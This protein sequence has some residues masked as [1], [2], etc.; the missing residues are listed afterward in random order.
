MGLFSKIF[1]DEKTEKAA[2]D[3]LKGILKSAV[4]D[5]ASEKAPS[6][7]AASAP[8]AS[9]PA[10]PAA[11]PA[12]DRSD[13]PSGFSWGPVMPD[14]LNQYNYNGSYLAYFAEIFHDEFSEYTIKQ[15][16]GYGGISKS[17]LFKFYKDEKLALVVELLPK[18]SE[19]R[20]VREK[21]RAQG[22][23]YLR[24]YIDYEGWWNT[25]AYVVKRTG[26]ALNR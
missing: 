9:A 20:K 16:E 18:S 4:D 14:E 25:R 6:A 2:V 5:K 11:A 10:A 19:A 15:E 3:L 24:Y 23:P 21:C 12:E 13:E 22:I 17:A 26:D 7:P 8:A 1:N